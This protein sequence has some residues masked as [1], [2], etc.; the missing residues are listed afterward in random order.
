MASNLAFIGPELEDEVLQVADLQDILYTLTA[1]SCL[2]VAQPLIHSNW[3]TTLHSYRLFA[4]SILVVLHCIVQLLDPLSDVLNIVF[5][6]QC[7]SLSK[8]S[9][10]FL[11]D[12]FSAVYHMRDTA[13]SESHFLLVHRLLSRG[14]YSVDLVVRQLRMLLVRTPIDNDSMLIACAIFAPEIEQKAPDLFA[15]FVEFI[16]RTDQGT[17]A[18]D[19]NYVRLL[20]QTW[21][22]LRASNYQLLK[23]HLAFGHP[24]ESVGSAIRRD[25]LEMLK[26]CADRPD[27]NPNQ[28]LT[29]SALEFAP[30]ISRDPSL[31]EY[32]AFY[33]SLS[34][35][36]FL[37]GIGA[38]WALSDK[39]RDGDWLIEKLAIAGGKAEIVGILV[40]VG[41][42]FSSCI[43][44][45]IQ[46]HRTELFTWLIQ[47]KYQDVLTR[48]SPLVTICSASAAAGNIRTLLFCF[49]QR[50]DINAR[51]RET[52]PPLHRAIEACRYTAARLILAHPLVKVNMKAGNSEVPLLT[53]AKYGLTY[54]IELLLEHDDVDP[55]VKDKDG[56]TPLHQACENNHVET[57]KLLLRFKGIELNPRDSLTK[58]TPLHIASEH[59]FPDVLRVPL[60]YDGPGKPVEVNARDKREVTPLIMIADMGNTSCAK[61]L[62]KCK[63]I[64]LNAQDQ[65]GKS[66]LH[67][68]AERG[69]SEVLSLLLSTKAV[70]VNLKDGG[71]DTALHCAINGGENKP[72]ID[73]VK[74]LLK[75]KGID[76]AI[77][78][79]CL[80]L[81]KLF[82][83]RLLNV[84]F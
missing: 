53:A 72:D 28:R 7:G 14:L 26:R 15:S 17:K 76:I 50:C 81:R 13:A 71:G 80:C 20:C 19:P 84:C 33:G 70:N 32:A 77:R 37:L 44:V 36:T 16:R 34:S 83:C 60:D 29:L 48:S 41:L 6:S 51:T 74:A 79:V 63:G 1:S 11:S 43:S 54:I 46:F 5:S 12:L 25:D 66:A 59:G 38:D 23:G 9:K 40:L 67:V 45:A 21:A 8:W 68:A 2:S 30:L 10:P 47:T 24:A 3:G 22:N 55:N 39:T 75:V 61:L 69:Y 57:V 64:D 82:V 65:D 31:L 27:F 62:L 58:M 52:F 73:V 35:F 49:D 42:N 4:N 56:Y 78:N 18:T